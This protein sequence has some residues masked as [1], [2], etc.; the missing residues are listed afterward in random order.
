VETKMTKNLDLPG[1]I[2][3]SPGYVAK[4]IYKMHQ[5]R[6]DEFYVPGY[7]YFIMT[8]IKLIPEK[9]FKKLNI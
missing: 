9:M 5:K 8:F 1:L 2:T 6:V 3:V 4:K 7:W